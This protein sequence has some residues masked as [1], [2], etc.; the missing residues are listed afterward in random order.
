MLKK[1]NDAKTGRI[2]TYNLGYRLNPVRKRYINL[3]YIYYFSHQVCGESS[4]S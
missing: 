2:Y 1:H 3:F 4:I